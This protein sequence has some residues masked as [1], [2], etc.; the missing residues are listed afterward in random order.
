VSKAGKKREQSGPG[1]TRS[2]LVAFLLSKRAY[3]YFA[4]AAILLAGILVYSNSLICSF[5][6]DDETSIVYNQSIRNPWDFQ[7]IW[8]YVPTRFLTYWT[9][10]INRS[11]GGL[12][13]VGYH[14]VNIALHLSTALLVW[15]LT[16]LTF[17]TPSVRNTP[18][19]RHSK[20]IALLAGLIFA[21]HPV[22]TEAV[23]Y[24]AQRAA[25]LATLFYAA[26][27]VLYCKARLADLAQE[28]KSRRIWF[29]AG[30][31]CAA[32]VGFFTKEIIITLPVAVLLYEFIFLRTGGG[33]HWKFVGGVFLVFVVVLGGLVAK[34]IIPLADTEGIS[35]VAYLMTEFKVLLIYVKLLV[36]P[37]AQNLDYDVP[38]SSGFFESSTIIGF[39]AI[40][41][42]VL[43]GLR[44]FKNHRILA[45]GIFWFLLTL[46]PE[47]SVFP[48]RDVIYEHRLYLPMVGCSMLFAALPFSLGRWV[49]PRLALSILL[50]AVGVFGYLT[51]ER[52]KV[53]KDDWTLWND[54]I[55]KSP[56]KARPYNNRG[57]AF[58]QAGAVDRAIADFDVALAL[59][60]QQGPAFNNRGNA[61]LLLGQYEK[62]IADYDKALE[63]GLTNTADLTRLYYNR[64]LAYQ[65][66]GEENL[67]LQDVNRALEYD[68]Y[69]AEAYYNRAIIRTARGDYRGAVED[70]TRSLRLKP[71][72]VKALNNRGVVYKMLGEYE[73]ALRDLDGAIQ[74][75]PTYADAY[76]NRGGIWNHQ[77]KADSAIADFTMAIRLRPDDPD[78]YNGRGLAYYSK[79][80]YAQ[81]LSDYTH[82]IQL[83]P[84]FAES[85]RGRALVYYAMKDLR[86]A[87]EDLSKAEG[88]GLRDPFL[89]GFIRG[90]KSR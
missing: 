58:L 67:A 64:G 54:V 7:A 37:L 18:I 43:I 85:Y 16:L 84:K 53:W 36:V 30:A 75:Q 14:L 88:L 38:I 90:R 19:A 42:L 13:V 69:Y 63:V 62:A 79:R 21:V 40:V 55:Q 17:R 45:F 31:G 6:F 56:N 73:R 41:A 29:Y 74:L 3:P 51:F 35:R 33:I 26:A 11:V 12:D 34:G 47:S 89:D 81:A 27:L 72:N 83:N 24:V 46:V 10:A 68:P 8:S 66:K 48:I 71:G 59:D 49:P 22:Q 82:A 86:K 32:I 4:A 28:S 9:F 78:G 65:S 1:G 52:N 70:Y 2:P 20:E 77:Q 76:F 5:H 57:R 25:S 61:F 50:L 60:P 39:L 80:E 87:R 15:W 44:L 23:T